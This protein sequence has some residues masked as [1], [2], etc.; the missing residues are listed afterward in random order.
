MRRYVSRFQR[1]K[2][3]DAARRFS[4]IICRLEKSIPDEMADVREMLLRHL[5]MIATKIARGTYEISRADARST[6]RISSRSAET[7]ESLIQRLQLAGI[8]QPNDLTE[9]LEAV[10]EVQAGLKEILARIDAG[11]A[12]RE[13]FRDL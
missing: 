3:Y 1:L 7:C 9:A 13:V 11:L 5:F 4:R 12:Q 2:T 8:G 10:A 6:F